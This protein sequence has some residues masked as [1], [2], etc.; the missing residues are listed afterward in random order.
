MESS[1]STAKASEP[2]SNRWASFIGATIALLT[3]TIP[4]LAI[5][6]YSSPSGE[7]SVPNSSYLLTKPDLLGE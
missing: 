7:L 3:L 2:H 4:L 5:S 6:Y 1:S